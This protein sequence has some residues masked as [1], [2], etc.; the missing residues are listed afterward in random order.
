MAEEQLG[1]TTGQ[2]IRQVLRRMGHTV[3]DDTD[4]HVPVTPQQAEADRQRR[5]AE[6]AAMGE[7]AAKS[8]DQG[9]ENSGASPGAVELAR[10]HLASDPVCSAPDLV[11]CSCQDPKVLDD[12]VAVRGCGHVLCAIC[13]NECPVC[14]SKAS[15]SVPPVEAA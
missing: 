10:T 14:E 7:M 4:E 1:T 8:R 5:E 11:C 12:T 6:A 3:L 15:E 2:Q 13:M 9:I